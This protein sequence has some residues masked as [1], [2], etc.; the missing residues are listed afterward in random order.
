MITTNTLATIAQTVVS[1]V[2]GWAVGYAYNGRVSF[3][4]TNGYATREQSKAL[5]TA[6][7]A[8]AL[9][10]VEFGSNGTEGYSYVIASV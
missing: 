10:A 9:R 5:S 2:D 3:K 7:A 6:I 1:D 8:R 4:S